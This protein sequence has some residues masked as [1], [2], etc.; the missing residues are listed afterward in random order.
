MYIPFICDIN[1]AITMLWVTF[2]TKYFAHVSNIIPCIKRLCVYIAGK[3]L[4]GK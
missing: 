4:G 2:I 1:T 3:L